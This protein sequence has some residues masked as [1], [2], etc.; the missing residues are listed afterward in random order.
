MP[1]VVKFLTTV[2]NKQNKYFWFKVYENCRKTIKRSSLFL[3]SG[4][5]AFPYFNFFF[6]AQSNFHSITVSH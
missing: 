1:P 6:F 4:M 5:S 2:V 3:L